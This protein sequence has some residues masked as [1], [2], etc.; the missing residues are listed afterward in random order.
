MVFFASENPEYAIIH[1]DLAMFHDEIAFESGGGLGGTGFGGFHGDD[2]SKCLGQKSILFHRSY[3]V[4][5]LGL[6]LGQSLLH[7]YYLEWGA[8]LITI[9]QSTGKAVK[10][11][12]PQKISSLKQSV[13]ADFTHCEMFFEACKRYVLQKHPQIDD[14]K[15]TSSW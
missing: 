2:L 8:K 10:H 14:F 15:I 3:G 12:D 13:T 7:S 5:V 6:T 11:L 4:S 9:L 1:R